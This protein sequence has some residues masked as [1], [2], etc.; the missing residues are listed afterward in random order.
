M[1]RVKKSHLN[2][3]GLKWSS[4]AFFCI[5]LYARL[6][7]LCNMNIDHFPN[8]IS[9]WQ[10]VLIFFFL[11]KSMQQSIQN[12]LTPLEIR[13]KRKLYEY[14]KNYVHKWF[15]ILASL[16]QEISM[17]FPFQASFFH[18]SIVIET[19]SIHVSD[20]LFEILWIKNIMH[21]FL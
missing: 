20:V 15:L 13:I 16:C 5:Y 6:L 12:I 9:I 4:N 14:R 19:Y 8:M 11:L 2:P 10:S 21:S 7:T 18:K 17:T 1:N 3:F